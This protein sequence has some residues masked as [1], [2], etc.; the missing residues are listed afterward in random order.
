MFVDFRQ[1]TVGSAILASSFRIFKSFFGFGCA[2]PKAILCSLVI[3]QT[4]I[5]PFDNTSFRTTEYP[6]R[7]AR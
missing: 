7:S 3:I 2:L 1:Q 6:Y 4:V 5:R